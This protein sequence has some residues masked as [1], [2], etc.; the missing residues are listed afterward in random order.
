MKSMIKTLLR[1]G[2][3]EAQPMIHF[4]ERV[5]EVL[6]NIIG[7]QIPDNYYLP[8]VPKDSQDEWIISQ[9]QQNIQAKVN[10]IIDKDY[11]IGDSAVLAPLGMLKLQPV[12]GNPVNIMVTVERKDKRITGSSYYVAIYDDR[13][14]TLVLADPKNPNNSSV[15]NQLNAHIRNTIEGGYKV[16]KDKSYIDKSFM[17]NIIIPMSKFTTS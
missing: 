9:I 3:N 4:N 10:A 16:N 13:L 8:N 1:E 2:L 6:Y 12:K 17:G 14:P 7:I 15:G 11:P 5:D